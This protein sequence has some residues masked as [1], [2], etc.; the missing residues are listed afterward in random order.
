MNYD[1]CLRFSI[2]DKRISLIDELAV[3]VVAD[4]RNNICCKF[5][6]DE[7]WDGVAKVARFI[8]NGM[9]KDEV[10]DV[11]CMCYVPAEVIKVGRFSVGL[12]GDN[13]KASTPLVVTVLESILSE[14]NG[15]L[16]DTPS[17]D[18][19]TQILKMTA[20]ANTK[21]DEA[22]KAAWAAVNA[23]TESIKALNKAKEELEEAGFVITLKEKHKGV[24]LGFWVGTQAEYDALENKPSDCYVLI[25]DDD[26]L[27][28]L[29]DDIDSNKTSPFSQ[30][31]QIANLFSRLGSLI[32]VD[33]YE[34]DGTEVRF[35]ELGYTPD[36]VIVAHQSLGFLTVTSGAPSN[37]HYNQY[38]GGIAEV[39]HP[40]STKDF[41]IV[42]IVENGFNV[43]YQLVYAYDNGNS[44]SWVRTNAD[45][46]RFVYIAIKLGGA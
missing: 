25:E 11:D 13:L 3:E 12:Y 15:E 39:N 40:A 18:V 5:E 41:P 32:K 19:Y 2:D 23:S 14:N 37:S 17:D 6:C 4:N 21:A 33:T 16:P 29:K 42:Q 22:T 1:Q 27:D 45:G 44:Q 43:F 10:L 26:T 34:G 20:D 31:Q 8:Y 36:A 7:Q 30:G 9:W 35:I 46:E 38:Y 28:K 24:K